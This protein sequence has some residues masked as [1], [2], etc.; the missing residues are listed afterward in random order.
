MDKIILPCD[1][2]SSKNSKR[3]VKNKAGR[4]FLIKSKQALEGD[5][6]IAPY[7]ILNRDIFKEMT[8]NKKPPLT[9]HFKFFRKTKRR[10]DYINIL[11]SLA[12]NMVKH[13]WLRDDCADEFL[14]VFELYDVDKLYPRVE[15]WV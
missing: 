15:I 8:A 3:I 1:V 7:M 13:G 2:F 12:D 14:P 4:L 9:V 5:K 10:F 11:Q 6:E